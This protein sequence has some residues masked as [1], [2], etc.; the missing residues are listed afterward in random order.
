MIISFKFGNELMELTPF[1]IY[2]AH[3]SGMLQTY[4][5]VLN[6]EKITNLQEFEVIYDKSSR[7]AHKD[8]ARLLCNNKAIES[9]KQY[10][11]DLSAMGA[12]YEIEDLVIDVEEQQ[13]NK[14]EITVINKKHDQIIDN[15]T[16]YAP[17][18]KTAMDRAQTFLRHK[19]PREL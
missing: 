11:E 17:N 7:M 1:E 14:F 6:S 9:F 5:E 8:S 10:M 16:I 2:R 4:V 3:Y 12:L 19:T 15:Y 13:S 18:Y